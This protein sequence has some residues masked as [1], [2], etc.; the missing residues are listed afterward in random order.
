MFSSLFSLGS[1]GLIPNVQ[2]IV[3]LLMISMVVVMVGIYRLN[4]WS[5]RKGKDHYF[6]SIFSALS[7]L[8]AFLYLF[9]GN[10]F[11]I[12]A[13]MSYIFLAIW[14]MREMIANIAN[15]TKTYQ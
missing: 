14:Y 11:G 5:K 3:P 15:E 13:G 10:I 4:I 2:E 7:I 6:T 12:I 8:F 9:K 1:V